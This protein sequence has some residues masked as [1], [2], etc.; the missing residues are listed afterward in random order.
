MASFTAITIAFITGVIGPILII[1]IK[2][3]LD[4]AKVKPDMVADALRIGELVS[5]RIDHIRE[6][7]KADRVWISQFHNG[8]HFYPT[9]KSIAKFSVIYETVSSNTASIQ[10]NFQNI[11]V[12]LFTKSM[13]QLLESDIIEIP[14][15]K[16]ESIATYGLKYIAEES[17]CKSG[18]LFA[19][20]TLDDKFIGVLGIDYTKRKTRLDIESINHLAI[21]SS[22]LGGALMSH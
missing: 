12:N 11:P 9:G 5:S 4:R 21:H 16:D 3:R 15:Y 14:D 6:D 2:N 1:I 8:G 17:N 22:S 18:Y 10:S 13:N 7:F 19:I 20:K